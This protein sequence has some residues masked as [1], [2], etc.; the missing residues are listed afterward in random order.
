MYQTTNKKEKA[1]DR[2]DET[3]LYMW[4]TFWIIVALLM[5]A[6]YKMKDAKVS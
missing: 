2:I 3:F 5:S 1:L 4:L 6:Y